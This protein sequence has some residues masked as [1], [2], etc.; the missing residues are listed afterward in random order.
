MLDLAFSRAF[1]YESDADVIDGWADFL[2]S[3]VVEDVRP[4]GL[5]PENAMTAIAGLRSGGWLDLP[6]EVGFAT[7]AEIVRVAHRG[8]IPLSA[9]LVEHLVT[10][11]FLSAL[12]HERSAEGVSG[13]PYPSPTM[14]TLVPETIASSLGWG[15]LEQSSW[16]PFG[17]ECPALLFSRHTASDGAVVA[18]IVQPSGSEP[19]TSGCPDV[20]LR[21]I[22]QNRHVGD[23]PGRVIVGTVSQE[24]VRA[25]AGELLVLQSAALVGQAEGLLRRTAEYLSIRHQFGVPIGSFQAVKHRLVD[26]AT[27]VYASAALARRVARTISSEGEDVADPSEVLRL[28]FAAKSL[29]GR[30][31]QRLAS[32]A[33]QLHGGI[34][35]TWEGKVH[36]SLSRIAFFN[37]SMLP[38]S[39]CEEALFVQLMGTSDDEIWPAIL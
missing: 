10:I 18:A 3:I 7:L 17:N 39:A 5:A 16:I 31:A 2:E 25:I 27:D 34:G 33:L 28:A 22:E 12:G 14:F 6:H 21:V 9:P 19:L 35:F 11:R 26:A 38:P 13:T 29:A 8:E 20:T 30:S 32:E 23:A 15:S 4:T 24:S 37:M 1:S 36:F